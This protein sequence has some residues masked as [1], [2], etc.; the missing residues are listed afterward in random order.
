MVRRN[1]FAAMALAV[2]F[3][4]GANSAA[5]ACGEVSITEMNWASAAVVT[6]VSKFLM[7]Q[8]Y[9]CTVTVVPSDTNP[10]VTSVA[11]TGKPDIVTELWVNSTPVYRKLEAEGK[12]KTLAN[13][14][15][16]GGVEGFWVPAWLA[17]ANP[18]ATKLDAILAD[19][20]IVGGR[21]HNCPDGWGCRTVNDSLVKAWG[22]DST[23]GLEVFNHGSG[24]TLA[25]SI[26]AA[27]QDK[28]PWFGYYWAPTAVLGKYE[29][30]AV[31]IGPHVPDV[32]RCNADKDCDAV[33]KSAYPKSDVL[34]VA[35]TDFAE[36]EPEIAALMSKVQFS[37]ALMG[38][39]LAWKEEN[40]A[41]NDETAV[42]F[43]TNHRDV[44][45]DWI[46]DAAKTKLSAL[47][48]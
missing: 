1:G 3:G 2:T 45:S 13:V 15:S 31:D 25:T 17:E 41:S 37:N 4:A 20:S 30:A 8:G 43:L 16:D 10:A 18:K 11:E 22:M 35:T 21:F 36:R 47:L 28:A 38:G 6:A 33:G 26:A 12:V 40:N 23:E 48:N 27:F 46:G 14:L 34:T 7:E 5:A 19:P 24:E 44:W 9:G 42:Y 32:H 39:L 29:M